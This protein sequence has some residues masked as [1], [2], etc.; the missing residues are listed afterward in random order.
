[1]LDNHVKKQANLDDKCT[2]GGFALT[3]K[4]LGF[5][6]CKSAIC[7][8]IDCENKKK[9]H[10]ENEFPRVKIPAQSRLG[11]FSGFVSKH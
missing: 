11:K 9:Y 2:L 4:N 7:E 1:M 10:R 5:P 3:E 6:S 8:S